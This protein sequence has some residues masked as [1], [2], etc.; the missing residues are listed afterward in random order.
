MDD[1]KISSLNDYINDKNED[2]N[3]IALRNVNKRLKLNYGDNYGLEV[4]SILGKGTSMILT[5]PYII[6]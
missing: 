5:L 3:G 2:F 1:K 4:M 6:R